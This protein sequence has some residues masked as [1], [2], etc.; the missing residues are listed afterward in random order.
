MPEADWHIRRE[1]IFG[2][3]G[4]ERVGPTDCPKKVDNG[5]GRANGPL[6]LFMICGLELH[7]PGAVIGTV[8]GRL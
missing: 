1:R 2:G 5:T 4:V 3:G 8:I 6:V 7:D